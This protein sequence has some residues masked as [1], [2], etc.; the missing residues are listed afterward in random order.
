MARGIVDEISCIPMLQECTA[1]SGPCSTL[2]SASSSVAGND[3]VRHTNDMSA[4]HTQPT[5][6]MNTM[7]YAATL[8]WTLQY[9]WNSTTS[10][11]DC[12]VEI[13]CQGRQPTWCVVTKCTCFTDLS[14]PVFRS[15][16]H[17]LRLCWLTYIVALTEVFVA[18]SHLQQP[19]G[20][21]QQECSQNFLCC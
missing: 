7:F 18:H 9:I 4:D 6:N 19:Q 5:L 12:F 21:M 15:H 11:L 1:M 20:H 2:R 3:T 16:K 17:R 13:A 14:S 8:F 10:L